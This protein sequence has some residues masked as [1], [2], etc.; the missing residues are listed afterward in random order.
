[1]SRLGDIPIRIERPD[2]AAMAGTIGGGVTAIL[3][4]IAALLDRLAA[5]DEPQA[6]DLKSLPMNPGDR[7]QLIEALG[8]GEVAITLYADGES[9]IRETGVHGVWWTEHRDGDGEVTAAFIEIA[10]VPGILIV[11]SDEL[12][13]GAERLRSA[14]GATRSSE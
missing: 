4:E 1:M 10:R 9:T 5:G 2:F 12:Q 8:S 14:I 6:I 11:D 7:E 3:A 13:R